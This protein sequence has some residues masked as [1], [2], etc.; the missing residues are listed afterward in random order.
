MLALSV[1]STAAQYKSQS[2]EASATGKY[3]NKRYKSVAEEAIKSYRYQLTDLA[4][5]DSQEE[6][7]AAERDKAMTEQGRVA[8]SSAAVSAAER[9]VSGASIEDLYANFD[10]I[11]AN[12]HY[13]HQTNEK[14]RKDQLRRQA[15]GLHA[16]TQSRISGAAPAPV[17]GPS[18]LA[19][20][21][22]I[23]GAVAGAAGKDIERNP[24]NWSK[25]WGGTKA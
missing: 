2:D 7:A 16:D 9:G 23:G 4:I 11:E 15:Q 14:W 24:H 3:Q 12:Q 19:A 20:G 5:R 25:A 6:A 18:L 1:A 21:L 13:I 8:A 10:A 22:T 17:Q